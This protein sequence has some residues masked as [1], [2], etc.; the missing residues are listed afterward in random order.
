[1]NKEDALRNLLESNDDKDKINEFVKSNNITLNEFNTI[2]ND[3]IKELEKNKIVNS[4][5]LQY[6]LK[7]NIAKLNRKDIEKIINII[8]NYIKENKYNIKEYIINNNIDYNCFIKF[9]NNYKTYYLKDFEL[10]TIK[11]FLKRENDF[12]KNNIDKV[13][14]TL[15]KIDNDIKGIKSY[16]VL[17][18]FINLGWDTNLLLYFINNN[19][20][21]ID[22]DFINSLNIYIEKNYLKEEYKLKHNEFI[23][24]IKKE[25]PD[26]T[27]NKINNIINC[28][29]KYNIPYNIY[30][31]K[32][33]INNMIFRKMINIE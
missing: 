7:Y 2:I 15:N 23:E 3:Y 18:Y 32:N 30:I 12:N 28:F 21:L 33:L 13:I 1:M 6:K 25:Y 16:N 26:L 8:N 11:L 27:K 31:F 4:L 14:S 9:I 29:N 17:E 22:K 20:N 10:N 19:K 5:Y 24:L